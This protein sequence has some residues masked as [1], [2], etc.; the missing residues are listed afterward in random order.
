M[1]K[2]EKITFI[3]AHNWEAKR[4]GGF[5]KFAQGACKAGISVVFFTFPRPYYSY[6]MHKEMFNKKT[7]KI[8]KNGIHYNVEGSDLLNITLPTMKLPNAAGKILSDKT[9]NSFERFSFY[10]FTRF[11]KKYFNDTDVFVLKAAME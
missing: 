6:F 11:A 9:M 5:H 2:T 4:L 8:L 10:G 1:K 7:L 3:S